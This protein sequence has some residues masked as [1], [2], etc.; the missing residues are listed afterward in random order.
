[1]DSSHPL[2]LSRWQPFG[3]VRNAETGRTP[4]YQLAGFSPCSFRKS[5][6]A[7]T[8]IKQDEGIDTT[9]FGI[10]WIQIGIILA[11]SYT[12]SLL[13]TFLPARQASRVYPAEALRYE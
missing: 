10:P 13:A 4:V 1:M 5:L 6:Q 2:W 9:Q 8:D 7:Y 3:N 11:M 12:A